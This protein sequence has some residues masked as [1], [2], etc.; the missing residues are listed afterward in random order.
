MTSEE[1][2]HIVNNGLQTTTMAEEA[3][4]V[5]KASTVDDTTM[6]DSM[7]TPTMRSINVADAYDWKHLADVSEQELSIAQVELERERRKNRRLE[8]QLSQSAAGW[9]DSNRHYQALLNSTYM[10][11][12]ELQRSRFTVEALE[13]VIQKLFS[14]RVRED[15]KGISPGYG[16][17]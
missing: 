2:S 6:D 5:E 15:D 7:R 9:V 4:T 8:S 16:R 17:V 10:L 1:N 11:S 3:K 12:Q 13:A 14:S